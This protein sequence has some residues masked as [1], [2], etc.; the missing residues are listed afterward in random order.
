MK[1]LITGGAGFIGSHIAEELIKLGND[2]IV[3]DNLSVGKKENIVEG[4][5]FING[6]ITNKEELNE[7]L[8]NIDIVFHEAAF[9]SIRGSFEKIDDVIQ[10][11]FIGTLNVLECMVKQNVKKIVF[12]S[13]MDVYG[14]PQYIPVD[15][16]H[17]LKTKSPYGLSKIFGEKLCEKF[18]ND[19]KIGYVILRYF[20]TY[21]IKQTVSSYVGVTT[22]FINQA[23]KKNPLTIYGN[24]NQT[25]DYVSVKDVANANVLAMKFKKNGVFNIGSGNEYSVNQIADAIIK[26]IGGSKKYLE[27]PE[28]EIKAIRSDI[29]SAKKL[30]DY[31]P[32]FNLKDTIPELINWWKN[33]I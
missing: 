29:S 21:G 12:A 30:L 31:K 26:Q 18:W 24:G 32:K 16:K 1:C 3:F 28:G 10:N 11:N 4:C 33:R 9:V 2:V 6:D 7:T 19:Y 27:K 5:K 25:R 23:L 15:E 13:S 20:N 8:K 22:S 17:P 14:E